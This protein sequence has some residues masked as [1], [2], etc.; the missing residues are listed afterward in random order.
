MSKTDKIFLSI[1]IAL[2]I[3]DFWIIGSTIKALKKEDTEV[4]KQK[5]LNNPEVLFVYGKDCTMFRFYDE[6]K[7]QY[8]SECGNTAQ[9]NIRDQPVK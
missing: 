3:C 1:G 5:A 9:L 4:D 8:F 7:Y 6:G 2:L